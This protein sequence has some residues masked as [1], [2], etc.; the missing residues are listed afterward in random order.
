VEH[1]SFNGPFVARLG[2]RVLY[3][4]ERAVFQLREGQLTLT[5]VAP[6][7]DIERDVLARCETRVRVATDLTTMDERI[8][9]DRPMLG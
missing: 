5:E 9:F 1:L 7:V 2:I 3:V 8:F 4:T 6:G